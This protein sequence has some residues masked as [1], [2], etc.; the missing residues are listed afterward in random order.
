M[1]P[2]SSP[3][4]TNI[5][6]NL[7]LV[8]TAKNQCL[9]NTNFMYI[10]CND[11]LSSFSID[12]STIRLNSALRMLLCSYSQ[13]DALAMNEAHPGCLEFSST[14]S[15]IN[16][17]LKKK[18]PIIHKVLHSCKSAAVNRAREEPWSPRALSTFS[19]PVEGES[20]G[21]RERRWSREAAT[22]WYT[23][24]H[25]HFLFAAHNLPNEAC[26]SPSPP[27]NSSLAEAKLTAL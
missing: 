23:L 26:H 14:Y 13:K 18:T 9:H 11:H 10:K 12:A 6:G 15:P 27:F 7:S 22:D 3:E 16:K 21:G 24:S 2:S 25:T 1:R 5:C 19:A 8:C 4:W 20:A 17:G